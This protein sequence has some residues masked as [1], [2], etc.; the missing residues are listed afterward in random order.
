ME[1][2]YR[3]KDWLDL[4]HGDLCSPVT[5]ATNGGKHYILLLVDDVSRSM[6][7]ILLASKD[8]AADA[9]KRFQAGVEVEIGRKLRALCTD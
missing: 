6:W 2:K 1:A 9:I 3:A 7:E 4:V 8:E 5:P